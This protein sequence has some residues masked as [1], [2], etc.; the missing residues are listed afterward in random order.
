MGGRS[1]FTFARESIAPFFMIVCRD[2][3]V[4]KPSHALFMTQTNALVILSG[5]QDSTL[6]AAI[7]CREFDAVHAITFDYQQRHGIELESATAVAKVLNLASHEIISLGPVLKGT[8]PL[9]SDATLGQYT[10]AA[11]LPEGVEPTFVPG[12]NILFLTIA[13]NRAYCLHTQDIFIGVC[14]ADF[15]GYWDCR[16]RFTDAMAIALG[17]GMYG[18]P[19]AYRIHTPLMQLTKAESVKLARDLLGDRFEAVMALTHTCYAGVKGGC[20]RCHA[21]ILRDRGFREAGISDPIWK[22]REVSVGDHATHS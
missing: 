4:G 10:S 13:A 5:G 18:E 9:V 14:E 8:S 2:G 7:A 22:F 1:P 17:E 21:C 20:G 19:N 3:N 15:A 16:M 12:R 6:C 11:E